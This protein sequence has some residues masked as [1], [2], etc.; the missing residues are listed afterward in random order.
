MALEDIPGLSRSETMVT[1]QVT[2][3]FTVPYLVVQSVVGGI[4]KALPLTSSLEASFME[5]VEQ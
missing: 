2:V 4:V 5:E 1:A 3:T